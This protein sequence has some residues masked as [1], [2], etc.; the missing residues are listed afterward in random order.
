MKHARPVFWTLGLAVCLFFI[1]SGPVRARVYIDINQPSVRRIPVAVPEFIPLGRGGLAPEELTQD[2]PATLRGLLDRTGLFIML[3]QRT[4]LEADRYAGVTGGVID[5]KNW[6]MIGSELL[7]KGAF[8]VSGKELTLELRLFD[9]FEGRM[10]IGKRYTSA[11]DDRQIMLSRFLNEIMLALT[12]ERGVFGSMIAFVG[13]AGPG[14]EI[15]VSHFGQADY[16]PITSNGSI[17]LS[18][19]FSRQGDEVAYLSYKSGR[20]HLYVRRLTDELERRVSK[21]EALYLSP[22]FTSFGQ[23]L[24]S[25]SQAHYSNIFLIDR[26]GR[27]KRQLTRKWGINVSPTISPDGKRFAFVSDRSGNPQIYVAPINGGEPQRITFEGDYNTDP[28]W[29]PRG[30]R[31][32]FVGKANGS[33]NIY[34]ISPDGTDMQQLTSDETDDTSPAWS[35]FGRMIVFASNRNGRSELFTMTANGEKQHRLDL[36]FPGEQFDPIWAWA[37]PE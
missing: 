10:L 34:T 27:K 4:F 9:V 2:L 16:K 14:K 13:K 31:L 8:Q 36:D 37:I 24:V 22:C 21:G 6:L 3:D 23:M 11:F 7:I 18:P 35:P 12:G 32:A 19:V 5:F 29:S 15:Y 33:F 20:P 28:Q 26:Y 25:I 1:V 17:N 30:D